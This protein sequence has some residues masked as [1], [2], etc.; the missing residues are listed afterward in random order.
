M[1]SALLCPQEGGQWEDMDESVECSQGRGGKRRRGPAVRKEIL[2]QEERTE[3]ATQH[4]H[5]DLLCGVSA[6]LSST[7]NEI[8]SEIDFTH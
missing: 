5:C 4:F 3:G 1:V 2:G 7:F 8:F 6:T